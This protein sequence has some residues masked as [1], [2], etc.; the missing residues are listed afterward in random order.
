MMYNRY[1]KDISESLF[2]SVYSELYT[3][4]EKQNKSLFAASKRKHKKTNVYHVGDAQETLNAFCNNKLSLGDAL[5]Y[6]AIQK[7]YQT[8]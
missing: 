2:N 8:D 6:I 7:A 3:M 4:A 5:D 1:A